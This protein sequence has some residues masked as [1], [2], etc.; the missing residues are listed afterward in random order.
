[1]NTDYIVE[2]GKQLIR[3]I[4]NDENHRDR[5]W[6]HCYL[7]FASYKDKKLSASD[8]EM[9][10]LHLSFYLAS[11]GMYRGSSFLLG[12]D[13]KIHAAA[14]EEIFKSD[15]KELWAVKCE[16]YLN[17]ESL[18][19]ALITLSNNLKDIY[20]NIRKSAKGK[21]TVKSDVSDILITKILLGTLAC[22]P[23]YDEHFKACARET[24]MGVKLT[25][26]S[27]ENVK[28]ISEYYVEHSGKFETLNKLARNERNIDVPQMRLIDMCFCT[29]GYKSK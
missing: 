17:H 9:L 12:K 24:L 6:E 1:M 14:I 8:I 13:Y 7:A 27:K 26:C 28:S 3:E 18:L 23:A 2:N 25:V 22:V 15:Y 10:C 5:S 4:K 11:F 16:D 20:A 19:S 29:T 21:E